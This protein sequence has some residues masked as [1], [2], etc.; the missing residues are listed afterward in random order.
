MILYLVNIGLI[1]G[2]FSLQVLAS[3]V[4]YRWTRRWRSRVVAEAAVR[5]L[6]PVPNSTYK[7]ALQL[8]RARSQRQGRLHRWRVYAL[9]FDALNVATA[10]AVTIPLLFAVTSLHDRSQQH[11]LDFN[12]L[13]LAGLLVTKGSLLLLILLLRRRSPPPDTG[14]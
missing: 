6:V 11:A 13:S 5:D 2:T 7:E 10:F 9:L 14:A 1:V 4:L 12:L 3:F 8:A